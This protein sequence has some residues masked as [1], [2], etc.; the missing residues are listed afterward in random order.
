[1]TAKSQYMHNVKNNYRDYSFIKSSIHT[2][3]E[4]N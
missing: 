2:P 3:I 4:M 1:M